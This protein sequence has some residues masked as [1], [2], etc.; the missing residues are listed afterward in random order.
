MEGSGEGL[1][2]HR[3]TDGSL[4]N[5]DVVL[6]E[7]ED[8]VPETSFLVVLHLGEVEI[9]TNSSLD[10]FTRIVEEVKGK[11]KDGTGNGCVVDG[12][13]WL[14]EMP[15]SRTEK[16]SYEYTLRVCKWCHWYRPDNQDSG[17]LGELVLFAAGFEVD[18]TTNSIVQVGL[19]GDQ[20]GESGRGSVWK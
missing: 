5:A 9:R 17:V 7:G 14:V 16:K 12:H 20:V 18:L 2:Q 15:S 13:P 3:C 8:I 6:G 10:E 1:D 4:R 19:T 11:V